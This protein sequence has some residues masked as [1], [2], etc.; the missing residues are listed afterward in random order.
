M[1]LP[2]LRRPRPLGALLLAMNSKLQVR[3]MF[4]PRARVL[5]RSRITVS[6]TT[7]SVLVR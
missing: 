1:L 6:R 5:T 4:D 2:T 7:A 3:V